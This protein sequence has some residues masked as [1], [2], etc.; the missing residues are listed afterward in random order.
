MEA[1]WRSAFFAGTLNSWLLRTV[2]LLLKVNP[3]LKSSMIAV[4]PFLTVSDVCYEFQ[5]FTFS[6]LGLIERMDDYEA[7]L[8]V[9]FPI[10][11]LL[12]LQPKSMSIPPRLTSTSDILEDADVS[13]HT[14][15]KGHTVIFCFFFQNLEEVILNRGGVKG[16]SY[17]LSV[18][19]IKGPDW[20]V[21]VQGASPLLTYF[22]ESKGSEM[23]GKYKA[24]VAQ[25]FRK[26][27]EKLIRNDES[28]RGLVEVIYYDGKPVW[29]E[30]V[31]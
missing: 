11:K 20:Y 14:R 29:L 25:S 27:L 22:E 12:I 7:T 4:L 26:H 5:I 1:S 8:G 18:Y 21:N 16:R 15:R 31:Q 3:F 10:K 23:L 6:S 13:V 9:R 24:D 19:K 17:Q 30:L 2:T 28:C